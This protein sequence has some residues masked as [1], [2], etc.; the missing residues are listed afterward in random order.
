[1]PD[2]FKDA[3]Y[4]DLERLEIIDREN[5]TNDA[6]HLQKEIINK[7]QWELL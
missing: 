3:R 7:F 5:N 4:F 6:V 1:M 2:P